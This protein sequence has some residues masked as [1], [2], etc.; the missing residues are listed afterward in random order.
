MNDKRIYLKQIEV[1]PMENFAYL[2]GDKKTRECII[3]DPAWEVDRLLKVVAEDEMKVVGGVCTHA[4]YDHVN[5]VDDLIA[6]TGCKVYINKNDIPYVREAKSEF[7]GV[8]SEFKLKAGDVEI[9]FLHTPG[10][11]PGSQCLL[12]ENQLISGDT[13]FINGCGRCDLPGGDAHQLYHSLQNLKKLGSDVVLMPGH[14]YAE[15]KTQVLGEVEKNNPYYQ[16]SSEGEFVHVR[17]GL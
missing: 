1:G 11:T 15:V 13:L 6:A 14:D 4:H 12:V 17:M 16:S 3:V 5:G 10:H 2:I 8:D 9:K 7:E